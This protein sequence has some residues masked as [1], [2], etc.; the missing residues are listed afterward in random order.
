[1]IMILLKSLGKRTSIGSYYDEK[2]LTK[3]Y[4]DGGSGFFASKKKSLPP[5]PLVPFGS[6]PALPPQKK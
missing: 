4:W 2:S 6:P 3:C 1:M 5:S